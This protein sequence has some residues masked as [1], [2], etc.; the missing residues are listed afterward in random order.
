MKYLYDEYSSLGWE[1]VKKIIDENI[2][3]AYSLGLNE[4][5]NHID[6]YS[7]MKDKLIIRPINFTNNKYELK[8]VIYRQYGDIA[9]VL[10]FIVQ[11]DK[12]NG[13]TTVKVTKQMFSAWNQDLDEV[14]DYAMANT[15]IGA[16]PRLYLNPQDCVDPPYERGAFMA[17]DSPMSSLGRMQIP[18]IT[19]TRQ[20]NGAIA[21]FYPGVKEKLA[22][23]FGADYYVAFTSTS[24]ARIHHKDS[25]SPR[26]VLNN[27]KGV[28]KSFPEDDL[29]SRKVF[30]FN[31][32]TG[33]FTVLEL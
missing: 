6:D 2:K 18:I 29:L 11:D 32:E 16:L 8:N 25:I 26:S 33:E 30:Y 3:F 21:M 4:F 22:E 13:L 7:Y 14:F 17:L 1:Q 10:Y 9:L 5:E 15:N 28:N 24:E 31:R 27:L 23:L 12:I 19:T 20:I